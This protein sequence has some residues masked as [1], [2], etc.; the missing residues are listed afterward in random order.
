MGVA[1]K[2]LTGLKGLKKNKNK[3]DIEELVGRIT[4]E[5]SC[6]IISLFEI[7]DIYRAFV[8]ING[9][10]NQHLMVTSR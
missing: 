9:H 5:Y 2:F 8:D 10:R 7:C 1:E 6:Y 3:K 4:L